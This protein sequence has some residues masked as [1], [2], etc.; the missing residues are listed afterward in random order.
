M[1]S[2]STCFVPTRGP[3][4]SADFDLC[5]HKEEG[6]RGDQSPETGGNG[7]VEREF[8]LAKVDGSAGVRNR[9][10][11]MENVIEMNVGGGRMSGGGGGGGMMNKEIKLSSKVRGEVE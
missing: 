7:G 9:R 6:V 2:A 10:E 5:M 1:V 11:S 4:Y 3:R 8:D